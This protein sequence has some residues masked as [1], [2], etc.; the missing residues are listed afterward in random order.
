MF[1]KLHESVKPVATHGKRVLFPGMMTA[2]QD[3]YSYEM[4]TVEML[5]C[6]V[7]SKVSFSDILP[8]TTS[9]LFSF[10]KKR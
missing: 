5:Y 7:D 4:Y 8:S 3:C 1:Q 9:I 10:L 2:S 6:E